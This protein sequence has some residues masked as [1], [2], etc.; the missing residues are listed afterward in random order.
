MV[1][2]WSEF[3]ARQ[4]PAF[5]LDHDE[6]LGE[7]LDDTLILHRPREVIAHE[8][9]VEVESIAC[10]SR[11]GDSKRLCNE[12][13]TSGDGVI[14]YSLHWITDDLYAQSVHCQHLPLELSFRQNVNI[15]QVKHVLRDIIIVWHLQLYH[16]AQG[17]VEFLKLHRKSYQLIVYS[18]DT[19]LLLWQRKFPI[20]IMTHQ[21]TLKKMHFMSP[22]R[23]AR[24]LMSVLNIVKLN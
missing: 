2:P 13:K 23:P 22:S 16:A 21:H 18:L 6:V 24:L 9:E 20:K 3:V 1:D 17:R 12:G 4:E 7:L 5:S 11:V 14:I 15:Y 19:I 8:A 10:I